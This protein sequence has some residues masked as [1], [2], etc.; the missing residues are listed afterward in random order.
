MSTVRL[1]DA[2][3]PEVFNPYTTIDTMVN[4]RLYQSGVL[5]PNPKMKEFL[6]GGGRTVNVPFWNDLDNTSA[7][8]S[9][10]DPGSNAVPLKV[11]SSRDM[12]IRHNRN[13]SW[14]D[15][16]LV[17][18][19]AGSD[20]MVRIGDR[21]N[22]YWQREKQR[23]MIASM[24]G[25]FA[26][27]IANDAG[28]MVFDVA[29]DLNK[30]SIT[31][32]DRINSDAIIDCTQ[33]MGDAAAYDN[34]KLKMLFMHSVPYRKLQKLN[35]I[36]YIPDSEGK[37]SF[38]Q[39]LGYDIFISD[40]CPAIAASNQTTYWTFLLGAGAF[41]YDEHPVAV[42]SATDRDELAGDGAGVE[43]LTSRQ[44][45]VLHPHG[46]KW[47]DSSVAGQ[48]P[49]DAELIN[50]ANWDRCYPERKQI[51]MALLRTNG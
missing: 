26:D 9:S 16:D 32:A 51:N 15:A 29:A 14:Q 49:T 37:I 41:C 7:N 45:W 24:R 47:T 46:I 11:T 42:P 44:Q 25:V 3:V 50:A 48:S 23:A 19:L 43:T 39:Y 27:N 35:L 33:T 40:E 5:S 2:V 34:N 36:D 28:D 20:P 17:S 8:I 12:A 13:Q 38:P 10:D 22:G 30:V 31:D 1:T 6:A 18:E 21:I 4:T